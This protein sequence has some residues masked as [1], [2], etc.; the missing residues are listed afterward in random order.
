MVDVS[1]MAI[2]RRPRQ[3]DQAA[4]PPNSA[5]SGVV[6]FNESSYEQTRIARDATEMVVRLTRD[7]EDRRDEIARI[8]FRIADQMTFD[9]TALANLTLAEMA[10]SARKLG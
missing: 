6:P 8:I 10:D 1:R 5:G 2:S 4:L 9:A 7:G 3:R